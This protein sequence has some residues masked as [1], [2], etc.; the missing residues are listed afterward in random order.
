LPAAFGYM[1]LSFWYT[2][3]LALFTSIYE[4]W[5]GKGEYPSAAETST[6]GIVLFY[7]IAAAKVGDVGVVD[8]GVGGRAGGEHGGR[9]GEGAEGLG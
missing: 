4:E 7:L 5:I 8:H 2:R 1:P 6:R 3:T 9:D